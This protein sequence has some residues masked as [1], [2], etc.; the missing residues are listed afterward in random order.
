MKKS[1]IAG[2]SVADEYIDVRPEGELTVVAMIG[3]RPVL[4]QWQ[5]AA[6]IV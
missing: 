4:K 3:Q 1:V 6:Q 2:S 5:R